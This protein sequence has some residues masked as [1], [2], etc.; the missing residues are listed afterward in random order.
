MPENDLDVVALLDVFRFITEAES[1]QHIWRD[2]VYQGCSV[3]YANLHGMFKTMFHPYIPLMVCGASPEAPTE[4]YFER[5]GVRVPPG[6]ENGSVAQ[7]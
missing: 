6:A 7:R 5:H 2:G 4:E 3:M 1:V